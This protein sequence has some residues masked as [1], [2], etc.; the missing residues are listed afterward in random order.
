M[1]NV[2]VLTLSPSLSV[3]V[4]AVVLVRTFASE[5]PC[6]ALP[7]VRRGVKFGSVLS[8]NLFRNRVRVRKFVLQILF[9]GRCWFVAVLYNERTLSVQLAHPSFLVG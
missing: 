2:Y 8:A 3:V 6:I 9:A 4:I 7:A 1:P 5:K